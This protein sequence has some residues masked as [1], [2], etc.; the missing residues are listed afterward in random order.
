MRRLRN[1][2]ANNFPEK[3][4]EKLGIA[5]RNGTPDDLFENFTPLQPPNE[6]GCCRGGG[7]SNLPYMAGCC[8]GGLQ[9]P[10][11]KDGVT[12]L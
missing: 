7:F 2:G 5:S 10:S 4:G 11:L 12:Q 3:V 9:Q 1:E 6:R 8:R